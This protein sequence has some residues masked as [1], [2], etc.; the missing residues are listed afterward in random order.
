MA[1]KKQL[2]I[3][4]DLEVAVKALRESG[5]E[6][7]AV[8]QIMEYAG[9]G[10]GSIWVFTNR[11]KKNNNHDLL[12]RL[13]C[14]FEHAAKVPKC[15]EDVT[16]PLEQ[17]NFLEEKAE[18]TEDDVETDILPF[19]KTEDVIP[20]G[21][22]FLEP[23]ERELEVSVELALQHVLFSLKPLSRSQRERVLAASG[24]MYGVGE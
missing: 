24:I 1:T 5:V 4:R 16:N 11:F 6:K 2:D 13:R 9:Q 8:S 22:S 23:V 15:L 19:Q 17:I 12:W 21:S 14:V 7:P 18:I 3:V 20:I 10:P